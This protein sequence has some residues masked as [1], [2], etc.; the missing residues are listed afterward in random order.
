[1]EASAEMLQI[2]RKSEESHFEGI[3]TGD[4]SRLHY[5]YP[6]S[7]MLARSLTDAIPGTGQAIGTKQ[8]MIMI[9]F[10]GCTPIMLS[11]LPKGSKFGQLYFINYFFPI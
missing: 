11:V 5:S 2:L 6:P 9:F 4:K 1:M 8:T 3:A 7:K 10:T